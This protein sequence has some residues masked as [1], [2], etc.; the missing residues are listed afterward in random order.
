MCGLAYPHGLLRAWISTAEAS[1]GAVEALTELCLLF[2]VLIVKGEMGW[3]AP[4][5]PLSEGELE[6][7]VV[8]AG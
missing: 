1:G 6:P 3:H 5:N 7:S 4:A 8:Y 2:G